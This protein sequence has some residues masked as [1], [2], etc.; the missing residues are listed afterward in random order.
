MMGM[1]C[2]LPSTTT[3]ATI[4]SADAKP[5]PSATHARIS[6]HVGATLNHYTTRG[7]TGDPGVLTRSRPGWENRRHSG[8]EECHVVEDRRFVFR[9]VLVRGRVSVHGVAVAWRDE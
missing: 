8:L 3:S 5:S 9:D 2:Q 4:T 6:N 7:R 1:S